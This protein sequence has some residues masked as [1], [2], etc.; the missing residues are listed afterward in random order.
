MWARS[1]DAAGRQTEPRTPCALGGSLTVLLVLAAVSCGQ[2]RLL[3]AA[4][5]HSIPGAP[6][7]ATEEKGGIR[8]SADGDDWKGPPA[9]LATKLTPVKVRIVNHSGQPAVIEYARFKLIG[10]HG[11]VYRAL[12]PVPL[13]HKVDEIAAIHPVYAASNFFVAPRYHD[14]YPTFSPWSRPLE[15]DD[16]SSAEGEQRW[17]RDLPTRTI[18]RM[19]L[20]EGVVADGGEISGFLYFENAVGHENR[21]TFR[22]DIYDEQSGDQLAKIEIPF[23][24]E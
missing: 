22:A 9:D 11:R 4:S 18:E 8:V 10:G 1:I 16:D 6:E 23:R 3:P 2:G 17:G 5:A 15:R 12:P 19:G 21:L 14:V 7:A 24:V 13:D 20:P